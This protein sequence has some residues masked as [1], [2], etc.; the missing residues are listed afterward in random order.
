LSA[1]EAHLVDL[2]DDTGAS[3]GSTTVETAHLSPGQLHRA[4]SVILTDPDGRILLQRRAQ[5]KTRFAGRWANACCGHPPPDV[6]VTDAATVRLREELGAAPV[7]LEELGVYVYRA[8][9]EATGRVEHEY[10]HVLLGV[11]PS[12]VVL[13]PDPEEVDALR[14]VARDDL[15]AALAE[16]PDDY[17]PWLAGVI[18]LLP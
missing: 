10:D 17:S 14:W 11:V 9:D 16:S 5:S 1:R 3:I 15:L 18:A 4:F 6:P 12:D 8:A 2:L 13:L 7:P